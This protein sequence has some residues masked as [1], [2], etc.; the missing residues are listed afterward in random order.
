MNRFGVSRTGSPAFFPFCT[1]NVHEKR[2][3]V[4]GMI[5]R[6]P[7]WTV[8][9]VLAL[10]AC[11]TQQPLGTAVPAPTTR[12]IARLTDSGA[13]AVGPSVGPGALEIEGVVATADE[14]AWNL[15]LLRVGYRG[16]S[17]V[18]WNRELVS[19]P[20]NSLAF[21]TE[22]K[23]SRSRSWLAAGLVAAGAIL[24]SQLFSHRGA[25][26]PGGGEPPPQN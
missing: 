18:I 3:Q 25:D 9:F 26:E 2:R 23:V 12:I 24:A 10:T 11:Y 22:K 4:P 13:V 7:V 14:A 5:S 16:G 21:V 20:R 19:F 17:S 15:N 8:S 1:R 6:V